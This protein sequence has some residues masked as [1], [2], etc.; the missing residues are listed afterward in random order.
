M[1]YLGEVRL[2]KAKQLMAKSPTKLRDIAHQVGYH[3]S[4][5]FKKEGL[6]FL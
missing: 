1:D 3:D 5:K 4:R 2:N 6:P